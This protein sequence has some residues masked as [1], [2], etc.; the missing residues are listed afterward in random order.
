VSENPMLKKACS[1]QRTF[2][3]LANVIFVEHYKM[4]SDAENWEFFYFFTNKVQRKTER[5]I[6]QGD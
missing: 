6:F 4:K 5:A 1:L 2:P 3:R